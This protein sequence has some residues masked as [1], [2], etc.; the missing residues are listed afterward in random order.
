MPDIPAFIQAGLP[1]LMKNSEV[2]Y[3]SYELEF[4]RQ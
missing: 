2:L 1:V 3:N 4:M